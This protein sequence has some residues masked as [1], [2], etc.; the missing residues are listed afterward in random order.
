MAR[1]V[2]ALSVDAVE[3]L[4]RDMDRYK[5][6]S[7]V[8]ILQRFVC[9]QSEIK[10]FMESR[11]DT[12]LKLNHLS[13]QL[14]GKD[15]NICDVISA[16]KPFKAKLSFSIKQLKN[17]RFQHFPSVSKMLEKYFDLLSK[18]GQEVADRFSDFDKFEPCVTFVANPFMT[19]DIGEISGQMAELFCIN[20]V[21]MEVINLQ[22]DVQLKSQLHSQ[23]LW[24]LVEPEKY[25]NLHQAALKMSA[26]FGSTCFCEAAFSDMKVKKSKFRTVLTDKH[27]K[28]SIRVNLS[29]YTPAYTSLVDSMQ[30]QSPH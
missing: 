15:K 24:N 1:R 3:Q 5:W 11:E 14:Q 16:V 10:A 22:N 17:K 7:R 9:L 18:L 28:G 12:T 30:C 6:L 27:R 8:K 20:P 26:L 25:N 23:H 21:K 29:G 13:L 2:S 19:V 4:E